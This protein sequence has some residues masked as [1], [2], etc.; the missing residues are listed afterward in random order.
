MIVGKTASDIFEQIRL[1]VQSGELCPGDTLPSVRDLALALDVNRNTVASAYKRLT[2]AGIA[3][4]RGRNGTVIRDNAAPAQ[5][6]GTPPGL[7][8]ID[9]A[10][11]NPSPVLLPDMSIA[12]SRI[13]LK[14]RLYGEPPVGEEI[15][16]MAAR[17]LQKIS[18]CLLN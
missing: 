13:Q 17:G 15:A 2:D 5:Q 3:E 14:P 8:L 1:R 18:M 4:S 12:L 6:E 16:A 10:G 9:L 7:A 11:G